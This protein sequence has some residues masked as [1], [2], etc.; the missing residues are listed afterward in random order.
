MNEQ[1][2]AWVAV[3]DG[4]VEMTDKNESLDNLRRECD[5]ITELNYAQWLA[6]ENCRLLASRNRKEEWAQHVLRF[7]ADAGNSAN[8]LRSEA[9]PPSAPVAFQNYQ[10][11]K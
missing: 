11:L 4:I 9:Q 5:E 2:D 7:C 6:L 1:N 10:N 8:I 3:Q